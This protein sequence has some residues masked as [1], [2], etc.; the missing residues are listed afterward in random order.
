MIKILIT[1]GAGNVGSALAKSLVNSQN[2]EVVVAD[3]LITGDLKNCR[4]LVITFLLSNV[5]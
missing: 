3:N 2:Y 5:M 1:G 4:K